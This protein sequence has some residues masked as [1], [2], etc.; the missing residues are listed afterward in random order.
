MHQIVWP[1]IALNEERIDDGRSG[2]QRWMPDDECAGRWIPGGRT[3]RAENT[4]GLATVNAMV[5]RTHR[6]TLVELDALSVLHEQTGRTRTNGKRIIM[7]SRRT[8]WT[9]LIGALT[10]DLRGHVQA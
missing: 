3:V 1:R 9:L 2:E 4:G 8:K 6:T 10:D 5:G 7:S